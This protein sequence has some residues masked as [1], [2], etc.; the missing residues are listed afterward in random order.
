MFNN[1]IFIC[2]HEYYKIQGPWGCLSLLGV[3]TK[4]HNPAGLNNK[5]SLSHN[6]RSWKSKVRVPALSASREGFLP[7][8]QM[9]TFLLCAHIVFLG[10]GDMERGYLSLPLLIRPPAL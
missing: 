9:A 1:E 3:T 6:S 8:L 7:I 4:F 5:N 2:I 10:A